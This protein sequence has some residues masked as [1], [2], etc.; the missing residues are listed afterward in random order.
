MEGLVRFHIC[1]VWESL[2]WNQWPFLTGISQTINHL[3]YRFFTGR[4]HKSCHWKSQV[5]EPPW[6]YEHE[7]ISKQKSTSFKPVVRSDMHQHPS[8]WKDGSLV[9]LKNGIQQNN[10]L[11]QVKQPSKV[12]TN[13]KSDQL[14]IKSHGSKI[15][16]GNLHLF[17]GIKRRS[18]CITVKL[19]SK[20]PSL[21]HSFQ[22]LQAKCPQVLTN[23]KGKSLNIHIDL[24]CAND[25][26]KMGSFMIWWPLQ[27]LGRSILEIKRWRK[28]SNL[29]KNMM[30]LTD[31]HQLCVCVNQQVGPF[32]VHCPRSP[33]KTF[34][35]IHLLVIKK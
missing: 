15:E 24:H 9:P 16:L 25:P 11:Y 7:D 22:Y 34:I 1:S 23:P 29:A 6:S 21:P 18:C 35:H 31:Q 33:A 17:H 32:Y 13:H 28:T 10:H 5:H 4:T 20:P 2:I 19:P 30:I 12:D 27:I 3:Q 8:R 14:K 26:H